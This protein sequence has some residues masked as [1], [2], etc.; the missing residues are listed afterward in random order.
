MQIVNQDNPLNAPDSIALDP[1]GTI[2]VIDAGN[3]RVQEFDRDGNFLTLWGSQGEGDGQFQFYSSQY[4][5]QAGDVAVDAAG[6][7]Y[8]ADYG[9]YRVQKFDRDGKFLAKWGSQGNEDGQFKSP[10]CIAV[11]PQGNVYVTDFEND[12]IQ[13][14]D[15]TGKFLLKWGG[16]G[17]DNGQLNGP[18]GITIDQR[19]KVYVA[20]K[21]NGRLQTFDDKGNFIAKLS[22]PIVDYQMLDVGDIT[23]DQGGNLYVPDGPFDR[24]VKLDPNGKVLAV[25]GSMGSDAGQFAYPSSV[26]VDTS[27]NIY[28]ADYYNGRVQK[29]QQP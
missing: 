16:T 28:V 17:T 12:V 6:N 21:H 2:Y 19:G 1:Q 7:V 4:N 27:G 11:D 29:F 20:D 23:V 14:F 25:W 22:W 26:A 9:N 8:V 3:S 24:V 5:Q 13:K 10:S 18:T 15:A